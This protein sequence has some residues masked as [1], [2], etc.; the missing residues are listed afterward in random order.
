MTVHNSDQQKKL[1]S[2]QLA[3]HT[4]QQWN[5]ARTRKQSN[6]KSTREKKPSSE[7]EGAVSGGVKDTLKKSNLFS[8]IGHGARSLP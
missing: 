2:K 8:I 6:E 4:L 1:Y 3:E 7:S 5:A